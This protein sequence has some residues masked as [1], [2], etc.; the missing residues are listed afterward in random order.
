MKHSDF[1]N[2]MTVQAVRGHYGNALLDGAHCL[3]CRWWR[4]PC[5]ACSATQGK[6]GVAKRRLPKADLDALLRDELKKFRRS[7]RAD[8][9]TGRLWT[10]P[11]QVNTAKTSE[12]HW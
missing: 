11:L 6:S 7:E 1:E 10:P 2:T 5:P 9:E 3:I 4:R 8:R 12:N